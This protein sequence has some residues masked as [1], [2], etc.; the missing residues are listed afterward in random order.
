LGR[1]WLI[2]GVY[3]RAPE[4][5]YAPVSWRMDQGELV[6]I[7]AKGSWHFEEACEVAWRRIPEGNEP[8]WLVRQMDVPSPEAGG[9]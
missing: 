2:L 3:L 1:T 7:S 8:L 4:T 5:S 6:I 9:G